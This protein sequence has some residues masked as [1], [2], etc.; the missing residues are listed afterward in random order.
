MA[1]GALPVARHLAGTGLTMTRSSI[2]FGS[3]HSFV[4]NGFFPPYRLPDEKKRQ[5]LLILATRLKGRTEGQGRGI[6]SLS[7]VSEFDWD[8]CLLL[9]SG[10][11]LNQR[12]RRKLFMAVHKAAFE[13]S[14]LAGAHYLHAI[15]LRFGAASQKLAVLARPFFQHS[16]HVP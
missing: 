4:W 12:Q 16:V 7:P 6:C 1:H 13:S 15:T 8:T 10:R 5:L 3:V 2:C 14:C 9:L 11:T